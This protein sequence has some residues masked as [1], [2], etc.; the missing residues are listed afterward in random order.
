MTDTTQR[1]T[2]SKNMDPATKH[3][4]QSAGGE[5][6]SQ[7]QNMSQLGHKGGQAAQKGGNAHQL[8]SE[9]RSKGG[10]AQ[11]TQNTDDSGQKGGNAAQTSGRGLHNADQETREKVARMG[12][13]SSHGGGRKSE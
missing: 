10:R 4:I 3:A 9:D 7:K 2:G 12:G 13:E 11:S 6:S 1:G 8:T 5:S